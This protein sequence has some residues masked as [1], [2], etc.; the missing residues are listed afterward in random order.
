MNTL[1]PTFNPEQ[2]QPFVF[3]QCDYSFRSGELKIRSRSNIS[4]P[5]FRNI[6]IVEATCISDMIID[7][8][9]GMSASEF[10]SLRDAALIFVLSSLDIRNLG[11]IAPTAAERRP[12][13]TLI[14]NTTTTASSNSR[15][16]PY[17]LLQS[18]SNTLWQLL[19]D[20]PLQSL[21]LSNANHLLTQ[22]WARRPIR[23]FCLRRISLTISTEGKGLVPIRQGILN[24]VSNSPHL[25]DL[26]ID[27]DD[28]EE[29]VGEE[30][31]INTLAARDDVNPTESTKVYLVM[32]N[33]STS[34]EITN[35]VFV[36]IR[37]T[38]PSLP[39]LTQ[40]F[41]AQSGQLKG[42]RLTITSMAVWRFTSPY[43]KMLL[44]KNPSLAS[45]D[46]QYPLEDFAKVEQF[47]FQTLLHLTPSYGSNSDV[48]DHNS[49]VGYQFREFI[50]RDI[51]GRN[52][53]C[54]RYTL[55]DHPSSHLLESCSVRKSMDMV[56]MEKT[57][58][59]YH[60][61]FW[62]Y[63]HTVR[64]L[65]LSQDTAS[66][67]LSTLDKATANSTHSNSKLQLTNI[68]V[69]LKGLNIASTF[70]LHNIL[71]RSKGI[72]KQLTLCGDI[73]LRSHFETETLLNLLPAFVGEQVVWLRET[74]GTRMQE[75]EDLVRRLLPEGAVLTL[76]E[77]RQGL[78]FLVP[79]LTLSVA[80]HL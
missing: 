16:D 50:L 58:A 1:H 34:L 7:L 13:S 26:K 69:S 11:L 79:G 70:H 32:Y 75:W 24:I 64:S 27:W 8:Q 71:Q 63:G 6:N 67:I 80:E 4:L 56:L 41:L 54:A 77:G 33:K 60:S 22:D 21:N 36:D 74:Q 61:F 62:M 49:H 44:S 19:N 66:T 10:Y 2:I 73:P 45:L 39:S 40:H 12:V 23:P 48:T 59:D 18:Y 20:H 46:L 3:G 76:A 29:A 5:L 35:G 68:V 42:G 25:R 53:I 51:R 17:R 9:S 52:D 47:I 57:G 65:V 14:S 38:A 72:F 28:L 15:G 30:Y 37:L 31:V 78:C 43:I 55:P